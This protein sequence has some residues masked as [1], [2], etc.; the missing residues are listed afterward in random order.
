VSEEFESDLHPRGP[1]FLRIVSETLPA[2]PGDPARGQDQPRDQQLLRH[3][4]TSD[5]KDARGAPRTEGDGTRAQLG[6]RQDGEPPE[7]CL[8]PTLPAVELFAQLGQGAGQARL[9]RLDRDGLTLGDGA[10]GQ[11]L[12]VAEDDRRAAGLAQLQHA[13]QQAVLPFE[14]GQSFLRGTLGLGRRPLRLPPPHSFVG[15]PSIRGQAPRDRRQPGAPISSAS[16]W[17]FEG[18]TPG[19]LSEVLGA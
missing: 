15:T 11:V 19:L 10:R 5:R 1:G 13:R 9:H 17:T 3:D 12:V 8:A 16:R 7:P 14:A 2:E 18:S 4:Q 6:E